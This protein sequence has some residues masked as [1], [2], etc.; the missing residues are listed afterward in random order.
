MRD[1]LPIVL[2]EQR[3]L[4]AKATHGIYLARDLCEGRI[5]K[6]WDAQCH[7]FSIKTGHPLDR[8]V[9]L[10]AIHKILTKQG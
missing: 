8:I 9:Q 1:T 7:S 5:G 4:S 10:S 2:K 3:G 6:L